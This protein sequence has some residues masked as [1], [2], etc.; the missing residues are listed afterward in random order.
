MASGK[1]WDTEMDI[2]C[3]TVASIQVCA[4][5]ILRNITINNKLTADELAALDRIYYEILAVQRR[6]STMGLG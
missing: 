3:M 5:S 4:E 2:Q 1:D 6:I